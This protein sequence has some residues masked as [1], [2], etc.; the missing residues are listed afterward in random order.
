MLT[1]KHLIIGIIGLILVLMVA[2]I[3]NF[4]ANATINMR[5]ANSIYHRGLNAEILNF[6]NKELDRE[7][8]ERLYITNTLEHFFMPQSVA[9]AHT[10]DFK[11]T[12]MLHYYLRMAKYITLEDTSDMAEGIQGFL[13]KFIEE[14]DTD[15]SCIFNINE[16]YRISAIEALIGGNENFHFFIY[17]IDKMLDEVDFGRD[18]A[19]CIFSKGMFN[20]ILIRTALHMSNSINYFPIELEARIYAKLMHLLEEKISFED[21][22]VRQEILRMSNAFNQ[23]SSHH[24]IDLNT[25]RDWWSEQVDNFSY[26]FSST[27]EINYIGDPSITRLFFAVSELNELFGIS[28]PSYINEVFAERLSQINYHKIMHTN[29]TEAYYNL[30]LLKELGVDISHYYNDL[31]NFRYHTTLTR[32]IADVNESFFGILIAK[33]LGF[34]IDKE[35]FLTD[36]QLPLF[37]TSSALFY[38]FLNDELG[39]EISPNA[40]TNMVSHYNNTL[41]YMHY[42]DLGEI[43]NF[44]Y[45]GNAL[46]IPLDAETHEKIPL[47]MGERMGE[48][49]HEQDFFF[50]VQVK[51][52]LDIDVDHEWVLD[53]IKRFYLGGAFS[54]IEQDENYLN[55]R[56]IF[57]MLLLITE[58]DFGSHFDFDKIRDTLNEHYGP[59]GG[60]FFTNPQSDNEVPVFENYM[61]NLDLRSWYYGLLAYNMLNAL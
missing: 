31:R 12:Y 46:N 42:V 19:N 51:R 32:V 34:E 3:A 47:A 52:F 21:D 7:L 27:E 35:L 22:M 39:R 29:P 2:L 37:D 13:N 48:D 55:I 56:S 1:K 20:V 40:I 4:N 41:E 38:Y 24:E 36:C 15:F 6:Y 61:F 57:R 11:I 17:A 54:L 43:Y 58:Y 8:I 9:L 25:H 30:R 14:I 50:I 23:I 28:F 10:E 26:R 49:L 16:V 53:N 44:L 18:D 5:E 45:L 60:Y 33:S 59:Y